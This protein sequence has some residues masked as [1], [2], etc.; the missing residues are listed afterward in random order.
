MAEKK[1][2]QTKSVDQII[3]YLTNTFNFVTQPLDKA[4]RTSAGPNRLYKHQTEFAYLINDVAQGQPSVLQKHIARCNDY[5]DRVM[6]EL[7][8]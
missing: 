3:R 1:T 4:V 5:I 2:T 7:S 6:Q 8:K